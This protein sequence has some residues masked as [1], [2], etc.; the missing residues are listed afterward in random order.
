[1]IADMPP[2]AEVRPAPLV[3]ST[4]LTALALVES[5]G[6]P[7]AYVESEDS[8]GLFQIRP[9]YV[10]DCNRIIGHAHWTIGSRW[11]AFSARRM[12]RLYLEHYGQH[13]KRKGLEVGP[14]ALAALHRWG[15]GWRPHKSTDLDRKRTRKILRIMAELK[16]IAKK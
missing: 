12:T 6:D 13:L 1:M 9:I 16:G 8:A 3:S 7:N 14:A 10:R 11:N 15:P 2:A 5:S 4:F